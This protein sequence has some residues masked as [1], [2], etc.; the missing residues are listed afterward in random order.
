MKPGAGLAIVGIAAIAGCGS[1]Q[2]AAPVQPEN[3]DVS[4]SLTV[5]GGTLTEYMPSSPRNG[6]IAQSMTVEFVSGAN[7]SPAAAGEL[8]AYFATKSC[9]G[10]EWSVLDATG[11]GVTF[12]SRSPACGQ[13]PATHEISRLFKWH[14]GIH[15]VAF[16]VSGK[17][18]TADQSKALCND[19]LAAQQAI[20]R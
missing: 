9:A 6:L 14:G 5:D 12:E 7:E 18:F 15:R 13:D 10:S 11:E 3:W 20:S 16:N 19:L 2:P 4:N 17:G 1:I 8:L